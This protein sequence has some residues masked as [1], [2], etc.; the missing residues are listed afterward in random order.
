MSNPPL[1]IL[2]VAFLKE[3]RGGATLQKRA[4]A[5][6]KATGD[7]RYK[8]RIDVEISH[9]KGMLHTSSVKAVHMLV[10]EPVVFSF[11]LW[12]AF[13]WAVTFLFLSVIPITFQ[14]KRGWAE[15]IGECST[16]QLLHSH[17]SAVS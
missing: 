4:H 8:A 17:P 7:E 11:G 3:T 12:I 5:M 1:L 14:Q 13:A 2:V 6:R 10:T 16:T 9:L 15:G